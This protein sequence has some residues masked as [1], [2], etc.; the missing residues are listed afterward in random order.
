MK[1]SKFDLNNLSSLELRK[2]KTQWYREA[3]DSGAIRKIGT[4][5]QK[6]GTYIPVKYG[7]KQSWTKEGV[8]IYWDGYGG[9]TTVDYNGRR[10]CST[11][12]NEQL[13]VPGDWLKIIDTWY[14]RAV[15]A[16][17]EAEEKRDDNERQKLLEELAI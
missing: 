1:F 8:H 17:L 9:Y 14:P 13:F 15:S 11:H 2:V 7:P 4:I 10:V 5:V 6:L 16:A 12:P 3:C